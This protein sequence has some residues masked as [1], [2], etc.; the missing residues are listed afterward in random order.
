MVIENA[1][2]HSPVTL[3]SHATLLT[4]RLPNEHGV[5]SNSLYRL[6]EA[7][8]TLAEVLRDA[9]YKTGAFVAAAVLDHRFGLA[10][11]FEIYDDE[12]G[13]RG[14][15]QLIAERPAASVAARAVDWLGGVGE[16]AF[17]LWVHFFDPHHPYDPP[18]PLRSRFADSPYDGEISYCDQQIGRLLEAL[19]ENG[20]RENTLVVVCSD[21]GESLGEHE[22]PTHGIFIYDATLRVPL[23]LSGPGIPPG[24]R[25]EP[26]PKGLVDV[27]PTILAR[28]GIESPGM[29]SGEDLLAGEPR[30]LLYAE[31]Y[32]PRDFYNW[33]ELRAVRTSKFKYI[34]A[35]QPELYDLASDPGENRNIVETQPQIA[36]QLASK[37]AAW[38]T[39]GRETAY[40]PE[41]ELLAQLRSLGYVGGDLPAE[42]A[43]KGE[44]PDPKEKIGVVVEFDRAIGL[45]ET[46]RWNEAEKKLLEILESDPGNFLA[47]HY[48]GETRFSLGGGREED[49]I[50]AYQRAI[51]KGRDAPYYRVRLAT[52]HEKLAQYRQAADE[53]G[54]AIDL[55]PEVAIKVLE[56]S[57]ELL[58]EGAVD[59]ALLYLETLES[60]GSKGSSMALLSAEAW[61]QKG[62]PRKALESIERGLE[63]SPGEPL[64]LAARGQLL[65]EL[66]EPEAA[67]SSLEQSVP[68]LT[69][70]NDKFRALKTM[71]TLSGQKGD[72]EGAAGYF[73]QALTIIPT[74]FEALANLAL[75][76]IRA[77]QSD[78]ALEPLAQA[79]EVR[80]DEI[81]LLNLK[82]EI[83][84]QR[85]E[86]EESRALLQRSLA[87]DPDQPRI[88]EALATVLARLKSR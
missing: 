16:S 38:T 22:E 25:L 65:A 60:K 36:G 42:V 34:Q 57:R 58:D 4:G 35:P 43:T 41:P 68:G 55:N 40:E 20:L 51:D 59:A 24:V 6:T 1:F 32:M 62:Q 18:E 19:R 69:A 71:A 12:I 5:R 2:A 30:E 67:L 45:F 63:I 14:P 61:A 77:G 10:Q 85:G 7:E 37:L 28:L 75:T 64:L 56:R 13:P 79:L 70:A 53:Y 48:L 81:R 29:V 46:R 47:E 87:I 8:T 33:S 26:G 84:F 3:P 74:D 9:G 39:S 54:R 78:Q 44:K 88:S 72:L 15:E 83:H 80:P 76:R 73:E 49:A 86:L 82:A 31:S 50:E 23:I 17:F 27:F 52:L 11:G 21:H 66:G